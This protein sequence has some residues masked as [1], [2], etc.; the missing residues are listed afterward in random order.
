[1]GL[2]GLCISV[3]FNGSPLFA[4]A[5]PSPFSACVFWPPAAPLYVRGKP[6]PS[7]VDKTLFRNMPADLQ[8]RQRQ[9]RRE[10]RAKAR[11]E[12]RDTNLAEQPLRHYHKGNPEQ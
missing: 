3:N 10:L 11:R 12:W 9:S 4:V 6:A 1:M 5:A 7:E 2:S 8:A